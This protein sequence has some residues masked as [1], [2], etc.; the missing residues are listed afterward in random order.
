[1]FATRGIIR[2]KKVKKKKINKTLNKTSVVFRARITDAPLRGL[3][4]ISL[5]LPLLLFHLFLFARNE[6]DVRLTSGA[7]Q[8]NLIK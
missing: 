8:E 3:K 6:T 5:H 4:K 1:M 2:V 7:Q